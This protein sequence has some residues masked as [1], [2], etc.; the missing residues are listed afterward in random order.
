MSQQ[1]QSSTTQ[2]AKDEASSVA[3]SAADSGGQVADTAKQEGQR[4]VSEA[5]GEARNLMGEAR[6]QVAQQATSQQSKAIGTV[7]SLG[8]ELQTMASSSDSSGIAA[9]VVSQVATRVQGVADWLESREPQDLL[10]DARNFAR[11]KPG[12][13]LLGAAAAGL[14]AGRLTRAGVDVKRDTS[15]SSSQTS[16]PSYETSYE[17]TPSYTGTTVTSSEGDL[18]PVGGAPAATGSA[19]DYDTGYDPVS[20][21]QPAGTEIAPGIPGTANDPLGPPR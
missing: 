1:P 18:W 11:R 19:T 16:L 5:V 14:A 13:F 17:T 10:E 8:E 21:T 9:E 2:T 3:R 7:R 4:V 6:A 20:P 12:V 15:S